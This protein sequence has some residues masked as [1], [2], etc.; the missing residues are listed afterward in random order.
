MDLPLRG[1]T[2]KHVESK[3][4]PSPGPV[5]VHDLNAGLKTGF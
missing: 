2:K 5:T 1:S 3:I 4:I